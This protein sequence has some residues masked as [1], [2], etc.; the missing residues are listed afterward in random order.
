VRELR[1]PAAGGGVDAFVREWAGQGLAR[2]YSLDAMQSALACLSSD[3]APRRFLVIDPEEA[4]AEILAAEIGE[5]TGSPPAF[6][7]FEAAAPEPGTCLL[8]SE[9]HRARCSEFFPGAAMRAIRLRS[10]QEVLAGRRRPQGSALV[11]VV[12][13]SAAIHRWAATLLSALGFP[14]DAVV[15][16][17]PVEPGWRDGLAAC[18]IVAAD[19]VTAA[20]LPAS[21]RPD[22]FR[23][24]AADFLSEL[25]TEQKLS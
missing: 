2:G 18:D 1:I 7:P 10:M 9:A 5:A 3:R 13:R 4:L 11:A 19:V 6:A 25:V 12:S 15:H 24:V 16:R 17:N 20:A 14:P 21:I 22:V 8:V 23:L